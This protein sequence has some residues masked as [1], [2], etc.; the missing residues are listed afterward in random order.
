VGA[1]ALIAAMLLESRNGK[2]VDNA[3]ES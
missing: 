1:C 2:G 3:H